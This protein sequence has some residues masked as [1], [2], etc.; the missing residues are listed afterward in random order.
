MVIVIIMLIMRIDSLASQYKDCLVYKIQVLATSKVPHN[1]DN[2][3]DDNYYDDN[4][5]DDVY[6]DENCNDDEQ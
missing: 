2:Y 5:Q 4:H 6:H 1:S 3:D